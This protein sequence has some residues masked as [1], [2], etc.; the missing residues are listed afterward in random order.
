MQIKN[1]KLF[2]IL[3]VITIIIVSIAGSFISCNNQLASLEEDVKKQMAVVDS[4]LQRRSDLIPSLVNAVKGVMSHE[5]KIL[6]SIADARAKMT[7]AKTDSEKFEASNEMSSALSRLLVITEKYP[8]LKSN[9][10]MSDL[11]AQLEG[12][13][14]RISTER[15]RY[16]EVV[17]KYNKSLRKF[18]K[19]I[20]AKMLG[21]K[22]KDYFEASEEAHV[23]P[24]VNF[25]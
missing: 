11:M 18:P 17:G 25:E 6:T 19:N 23:V 8:E 7:G 21:F 13:E 2:G 15:D 20:F 1:K 3:V 14:N 5:E 16:N 4:K 24:S 9:E 22:S 12:A 10:Q